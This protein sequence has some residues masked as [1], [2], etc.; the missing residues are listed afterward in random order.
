MFLIHEAIV[1]LVVSGTDH[2]FFRGS[3]VAR[4]PK[5]IPARQRRPKKKSGKE[6]HAKV[7]LISPCKL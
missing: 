3:G 6:D 5:Q 1:F 2:N 4:F 7:D